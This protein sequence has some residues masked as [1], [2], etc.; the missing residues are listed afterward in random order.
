VSPLPRAAW[1]VHL[2]DGVLG[3][4]PLRLSD[5]RRWIQTRRTSMDWLSPWEVTVPGQGAV[6]LPGWSTYTVTLRR[7]RN[8]AAAGN[9]LPFAVTLEGRLIGQ[10]TVGNLG[11][12]PREPAYV[13]YWIDR[14]QAGRGI[15]PRALALVL[16]H[17][18]ATLD[19]ARVEAN[20][21]PDNLAS[22]RVVEKL[23]FRLDG[24]RP[25]HLHVNGA[26]R[27]HLRYELTR[28]DARG[29]LLARTPAVSPLVSKSDR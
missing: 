25:G 14:S 24:L 12:E 1:P 15:I 9:S 16:D 27:D 19:L 18:F 29:G 26:W 5:A 20:I 28:E 7:L 4:R 22:R 13:G 10:V 8:D 3:V 2:V 17:A 6:P 21:Q 11:R 23:G